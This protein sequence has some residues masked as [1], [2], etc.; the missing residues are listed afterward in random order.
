MRSFFARPEGTPGSAKTPYENLV[1]LS[2]DALR[3]YET[4]LTSDAVR[5]AEPIRAR[6]LFLSLRSTRALLTSRQST[7]D[8]S[9]PK[10]IVAA[11]D[12]WIGAADSFEREALRPDPQQ[13]HE[14]LKDL[15]AK[16]GDARAALQARSN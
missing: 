8:D 4:L 7:G 15:R 12:A 16:V 9:V 3:S 13:L 10:K 11:I 5:K 14:R 6:E 2:A 1:T